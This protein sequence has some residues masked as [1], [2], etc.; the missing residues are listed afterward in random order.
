MNGLFKQRER[1]AG[2]VIMIDVGMIIPNKSQPRKEFNEDALKSLSQSVRENGILQPIIVRNKGAIYEIISGERRFRAAKLAGMNE[3]PCIV[4]DVDEEKS[5]VLA[6]IENI[7]RKDLSYFEEA[8]ALEKLLTV[9]GL[10]QEQAA[11]RLGKAQSTIAN[12][13]RLLRFSEA[14]R[15][16]LITG[17]LSERQARALIRIGDDHER[18]RAIETVVSRRLNIEQTEGLVNR[19]LSGVPQ[20][21]RKPRAKIVYTAPARL[22]LNSLN[23]LIKR[24]RDDKVPCELHEQKSESFYEYTL[25]FPINI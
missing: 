17:G 24:I 5:A 3:V 13:L 9:Y 20:K 6:L 8:A 2:Q 21:R 19:V 18:S 22:Y 10:T 25:R 14:E 16:L 4:K 15:R 23:A 1:V 12:K 11:A 7:Q